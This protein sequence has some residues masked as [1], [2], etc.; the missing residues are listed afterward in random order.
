MKGERMLETTASHHRQIRARITV[1]LI[2]VAVSAVT[3]I[4][5]ALRAVS[6]LR[7]GGRYD[8]S[9]YYAAAY[10]LFPMTKS[11]TVTW[12]LVIGYGAYYGLA[13]GGEKALVAELAPK[14]ERGRAYG[15]LNAATGF[16]VLPANALFGYLYS[17]HIAWAF[18]ISAACAGEKASRRLWEPEEFLRLHD[19]QNPP[20][21]C[22]SD[23]DNRD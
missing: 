9:T 10:A 7:G 14:D 11:I 2:A 18:G 20:G 4:T 15:A 16:A 8:F 19:C 23:H 5:W 1:S 13:E 6:M 21:R 12:A 3:L 22:F 17:T